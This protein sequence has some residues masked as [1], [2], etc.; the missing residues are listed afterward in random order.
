MIFPDSIKKSQAKKLL[1]LIEEQTRAEVV[2]RLVPFDNLEYINYAITTHEKTDEIRKFIY[3]T[4][5]LVELADIFNISLKREKRK[6]RKKKRS[7]K[8]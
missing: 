5:N 1:K 8:C 4:D 6:K 2:A 7:L 3:G